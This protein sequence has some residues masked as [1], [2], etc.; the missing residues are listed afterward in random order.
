MFD[1]DHLRQWI[2][3]SLAAGHHILATSNQ[4]TLLL[5]QHGG[6]ELIVK[7]A[8]GSGLVLKARQRTLEREYQAYLKLH[9]VRGIPACFGLLDGRYLLLEYIHGTPYRDAEFSQREQWFA[10]LLE[11]LQNI[12]ARGVCH[13]DLKSK[14]NLLVTGDERPCVIDFGT[15]IIRKPG[16]HPLNHWLFNTGKRLDINA[17]VKHK[18]RGFYRDA[19]ASDHALLDYGWLERLV[20][21]LSGRPMDRLKR[22]DDDAS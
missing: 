7:T 22:S 3:D 13:A 16:F 10:E 21:R 14:G 2:S 18:Y 9:G 1:A 4:G 15:S 11:I 20:R 17:W 12:H 5:Y 19:S 6:C 8:M